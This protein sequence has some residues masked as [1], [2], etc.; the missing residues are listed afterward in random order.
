MELKEYINK[1]EEKV[2]VAGFNNN[3]FGKRKKEIVPLRSGKLAS[4]T[5]ADFVGGSFNHNSLLAIN[6]YGL[7]KLSNNIIDTVNKAENIFSE[8]RS[9]KSPVIH[10]NSIKMEQVFLLAPELGEEFLDFKK[11]LV[12]LR[13]KWNK[14]KMFT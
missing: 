3:V 11:H 13:W 14:E 12:R 6:Y 2:I 5:F 9:I 1:L 10:F 4:T 8:I 7:Y